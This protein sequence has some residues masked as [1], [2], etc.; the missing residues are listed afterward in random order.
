MMWLL[1]FEE[2]DTLSYHANIYDILTK[3]KNEC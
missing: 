1:N 2:D 3:E